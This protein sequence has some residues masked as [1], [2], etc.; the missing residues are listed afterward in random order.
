MGAPV[1]VPNTNL[2]STSKGVRGR[3]RARLLGIARAH[4][5]VPHYLTDFG[6]HVYTSSG[7]LCT[8]VH[9]VVIVQGV[10]PHMS[11]YDMEVASELSNLYGPST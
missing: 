10:H 6:V 1:S 7:W 9:N 11:E 3:R 8:H 4:L 2:F 5:K